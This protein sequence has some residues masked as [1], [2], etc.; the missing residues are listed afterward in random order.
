MPASAKR[1]QILEIQTIIQHI[2]E[3]GYRR[4]HHGRIRATLSG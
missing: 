2:M 1:G 4:D 3:T